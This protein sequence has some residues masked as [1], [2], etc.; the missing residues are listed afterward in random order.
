MADAGKA[1]AGAVGPIRFSIR[2]LIASTRTREVS[3]ETRHFAVIKTPSADPY[4]GPATFE[5]ESR[6]RLGSRGAEVDTVVELTGYGDS[7]KTRDGEVV[8]TARH[9]L[10]A[11]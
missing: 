5:V 10:R 9:V 3:G 4:K 2:G 7:Y 8:Q 6:Q 1:S 11:L